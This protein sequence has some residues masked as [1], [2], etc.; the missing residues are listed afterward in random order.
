MYYQ[1]SRSVGCGS[2]F[3]TAVLSTALLAHRV[4]R[5]R[6]VLPVTLE[7]AAKSAMSSAES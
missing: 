5:V 4:L 3:A 1:R 7:A 2:A 6:I